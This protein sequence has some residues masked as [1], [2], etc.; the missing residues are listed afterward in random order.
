MSASIVVETADSTENESADVAVWHP[1]LQRIYQYWQHIHPPTGLP[2]RQHVDPLDFPDLLPGI[3]LL[4]VQ[5]Q[6]F[7]LRYR[8]A[9]T[10]IVDAI[11]REVTGLWIDEAHPHHISDP[12]YLGR[13]RLAV[14]T[15]T[16][17]RRRGR[18][19]TWLSED[20]REVENVV[21]PLATD[22]ETVDMLMVLTVFYYPE[23]T[24]E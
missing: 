4:D 10:R 18:P 8:L 22:G 5:R 24:S 15:K 3:W 17:N 2:G 13:Y 7:R 19:K 11:G 12:S 16:P 14:E 9:G 20:Y 6:P 23:G 1:K 21:L